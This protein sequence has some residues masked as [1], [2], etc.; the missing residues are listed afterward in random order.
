[1]SEFLNL[2]RDFLSSLFT[3]SFRTS[4][5]RREMR[6][7]A[8]ELRQRNPD[9]YRARTNEVLPA[10]PEAL[11]KLSRSVRSLTRLFDKTILNPDPALTELFRDWLVEAR[12]CENDRLTKMSFT[13]DAMRRR[14]GQSGSFQNALRDICADFEHYLALFRQPEFA[15]FNHEYAQVEQL[16][17]LSRYPF[18]KILSFFDPRIA[19]REGNDKPSFTPVLAQHL[20]QDLMDL[21]FALVGFE[22]GSTVAENTVRLHRRLMR[23]PNADEEDKIRTIIG[24]IRTIVR[25]YFSLQSL[26]CLIRLSSENADLTLPVTREMTD[27]LELFK[28]RLRARFE[29]ERERLRREHS[30]SEVTAELQSLFHD[31]PLAEIRGYTEALSNTLAEEGFE[32][33]TRMRGL[34]I[35]KSFVYG[36]FE[37]SI[38][39]HIK[40][41]VIDGFF[42][43]KT[44]KERF[45][46]FFHTC[47]SAV[48][49][50]AR[51]EEMITG[52]GDVSVRTIGEYLDKHR[53]G[54]S[55][56]ASL[57]Q[58]VQT[59][60]DNAARLIE[61]VANVFFGFSRSLDELLADAR[62]H[63]PTI[64]GNIKVIGGDHNQERLH[65][66]VTDAQRLT[67]FISIM[68]KFTVIGTDREMKAPAGLKQLSEGAD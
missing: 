25:T 16:A 42:E 43:N 55:V 2:I 49:E 18:E 8:R 20:T 38:K 44:F 37:T 32:S 60:N 67:L 29:L 46:D 30:E 50:I 39:E 7:A 36:P 9:V 11:Y 26:L 68:R 62:Q 6:A 65:D 34:Q 4:R 66:L 41:L 51:L 14:L 24:L 15:D 53:G 59:I 13:R 33:F 17:E 40:Q 57:N 1:M 27:H 56:S 64:V 5:Q 58:L 47:Q 22:A 45:I 48:D 12:L 19:S 63:V 61:T 21:Y 3:G 28:S 23:I 54:K 52:P 10:F 31:T 35:V